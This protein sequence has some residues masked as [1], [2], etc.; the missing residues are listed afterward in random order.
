MLNVPQDARPTRRLLLLLL[1]GAS[2]IAGLLGPSVVFGLPVPATLAR[3]LADHGALMTL[4][5]LGTLVSLE[6][7]VALGRW[8]GWLAPL[9][10]GLGGLVLIVDLPT[11][12]AA[13]LFTV[14]G[15]MLVGIYLAFDR[16]QRSVHGWVQALGAV[17]WLLATLLLLAGRPVSDAVP[18]LA[19]FLVL[20]IGGERLELAHIGREVGRERPAFLAALGAFCAGVVM[21]LAAPDVGVRL[22]GAGLLALAAW[23]WTFDLAR[24]TVQRTGVTRFI[25]VC[26]LAGYAWM[27]VAGIFWLVW[28]PTSSGLRYDAQLHA[29]FLGFAMSMVFGHAPVILPALLRISLPYHPVFYVHVAMLHVGLLLRVFGGD[30]LEDP[31]AWRWG[32]TLN[33]LAVL[34]FVVSSVTAVAWSGLAAR[35]K[36][37]RSRETGEGQ[38]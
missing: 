16:I 36:P 29:L 11:E 1:A 17:G 34:L 22:A 13:A 19:A 26:L 32:G 25:A 2:L 24:R 7:A 9:A 4:G 31:A 6:R 15:L 37:R 33:V 28:G 27:A 5:F 21:A 38:G 10:T 8:W 30:V 23:F 14:G 3:L 35:R 20:T 12:L 18:A